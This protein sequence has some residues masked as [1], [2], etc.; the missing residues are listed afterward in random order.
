[1]TLKK[2]YIAYSVIFSLAFAMFLVPIEADAVCT[3]GDNGKWTAGG[4]N[5]ETI[6]HYG[7]EA[8]GEISLMTICGTT[9][10]ASYAHFAV[11]MI[12]TGTTNANFVEGGSYEGYPESG[13]SSVNEMSHF[14]IKANTV[15]GGGNQF[16]DISDTTNHHPAINDDVKYTVYWDYNGVF[17]LFRDYYKIIIYNPNQ[18]YT[19]TVS[20]IWS[21]GK[22]DFGLVQ[23]EILSR[24]QD[25]K[26]DA[27][28]IKDQNTS[29]TWTA[30]SSADG[31]RTS[32]ASP[33]ELCYVEAAND[34]YELGLEAT[35][36]DT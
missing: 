5:T 13:I 4:K 33:Y 7:N 12:T 36:C 8:I 26:V 16:T 23:S 14:F 3:K 15:E 1:M 30:W 10:S 11:V 28:T 6:T 2:T 27:R 24:N 19:D 20:N 17:P 31:L 34:H 35:P 18:S 32:T 25:V 22:G 21:N 29:G 9:N